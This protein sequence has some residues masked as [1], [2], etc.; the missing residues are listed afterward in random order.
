MKKIIFVSLILIISGCSTGK[1]KDQN[2]QKSEKSMSVEQVKR[3]L[4]SLGSFFKKGEEKRAEEKVPGNWEK[5]SNELGFSLKYPQEVEINTNNKEKNRLVIKIVDLDTLSATS[6]EGEEWEKLA[7]DIKKGEAGDNWGLV[8]ENS[9]E[10]TKIGENYVRKGVVFS[11][12][13]A[14][15]VVFEKNVIFALNRSLV[16]VSLIGKKDGIINENIDYFRDNLE[17]CSENKVWRFERQSEFYQKLE[18]NELA[19][20]AKI[21]FD[22][23]DEIIET[24]EITADKTEEISVDP[25][26]LGGENSELIWPQIS[27]IENQEIGEKVA[28]LIDFEKVSG[29]SIQDAFAAKEK[30]LYAVNFNNNSFLSLSFILNSGSGD[31]GKTGKNLL[32]DLKKGEVLQIADIFKKDKMNDLLSLCDRK[33]QENIEKYKIDGYDGRKFEEAYLENFIILE[34]GFRFDVPPVGKETV[35]QEVYVIVSLDEVNNFLITKDT[36]R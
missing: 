9:R 33:L 4:I 15:D 25:Q 31:F 16:T 7:N 24:L 14:C 36:F 1:I 12:D 11:S 21:W 30:S 34:N 3:E 19:G 28:K 18:E 8:L 27:G 10:I 32:I 6:T 23:F 17:V 20:N 5:Y 35:M 2:E 26:S 13:E 22:L 29:K